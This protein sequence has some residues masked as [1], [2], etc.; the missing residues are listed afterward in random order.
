VVVADRAGPGVPASAAA[1]AVGDGW[2]RKFPDDEVRQVPLSDGGVGFVEVVHDLLG[3]SVHMATVRG[4]DRRPAPATI[5]LADDPATGQATAFVEAAQVATAG[6][7]DPS[8]EPHGPSSRSS[9]E[10]SAEHG[11]DPATEPGAPLRR[12]S[13]GLGQL[14]LEAAEAAPNVVLGLAGTTILDGGAGMLAALGATSTPAGALT[15][16]ATGLAVL[17][18]VDASRIRVGVDTRLVLLTDADLPLLGLRGATNILGRDLGLEQQRRFEVDGWLTRLAHAVDRDVA[19]QDGAG[20]G[21]GIGYGLLVA[22]ATRQPA[23]ASVIAWAGVK[24]GIDDADLVIAVTDHLGPHQLDGGVVGET[25]LACRDAATPLVVVSRSGEVST[26][27]HRAASIDASY[28]L[29][30]DPVVPS[31]GPDHTLQALDSL[32][33]RVARTWGRR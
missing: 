11:R 30:E 16:G 14:V 20:A 3:G 27:E 32:A 19:A 22:G 2:Q 17:T 6:A 1:R 5:L 29:D 8:P 23:V 7:P 9:H 24:E 10:R 28:S 21:G 4:V 18:E 13:Y 26:R 25:A 12:S 31:V 33:Q 15:A